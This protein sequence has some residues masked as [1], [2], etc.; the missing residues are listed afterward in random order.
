V[1]LGWFG[2][3]LTKLHW[4]NSLVRRSNTGN[5]Q[6]RSQCLSSSL[7]ET[8]C[9]WTNQKAA[10][11]WLTQ[12]SC[13]CCRLHVF[14]RLALVAC[15]SFEFWL[16]QWPDNLAFWQSLENQTNKEGILLWQKYILLIV[17]IKA[18]QTSTFKF[19]M[20]CSHSTCIVSTNNRLLNIIGIWPGSKG[21]LI[22]NIKYLNVIFTC[23]FAS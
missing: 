1:F 12:A 19:D 2:F 7:E 8:Y 4:F 18:M 13:G 10:L 11:T 6:L 21:G 9:L 15:F 5:V 17:I 20:R 22:V 3:S 16:V 23:C 14:P